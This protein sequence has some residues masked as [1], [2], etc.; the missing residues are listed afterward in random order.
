MSF[1]NKIFNAGFEDDDNYD[2]M[3]S[4]Y[5]GDEYDD[6]E[7]DYSYEEPALND[8]RNIISIN[9]DE[10]STVVVIEPKTMHDACAIIQIL[11]ENKMCVGKFDLNN[12]PDIQ[13]IVDF[14][15]GA[16]YALNADMEKISDEI[17]IVAPANVQIKKTIKEEMKAVNRPF[18]IR[19]R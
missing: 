17:F 1:L 6:Y 10:K 12:S 16:V 9:G 3:Y 8:Q 5:E 14:I 19:K 4:S 13:N 2:D 18:S 15:S 11:K 7:D